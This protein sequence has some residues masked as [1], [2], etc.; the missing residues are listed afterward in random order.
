VSFERGNYYYSEALVSVFL[1]DCHEIERAI[2]GVVGLSQIRS[3]SFDGFK[4]ISLLFG[5]YFKI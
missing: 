5:F 1:K 4:I 3:I 2:S